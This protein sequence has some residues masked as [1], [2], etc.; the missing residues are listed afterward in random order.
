MIAFQMGGVRVHEDGSAVAGGDDVMLDDRAPHGTGTQAIRRRLLAARYQADAAARD[1]SGVDKQGAA[2]GAR[3]MS[4][5]REL[6]A[7]VQRLAPAVQALGAGEKEALRPVTSALLGAAWTLARKEARQ[8][9]VYDALLADVT[10]LFGV[11]QRALRQDG[12]S[13]RDESTGETVVDEDH[14]AVGDARRRIFA[15]RADGEVVEAVHIEVAPG[16]GSAEGVAGLVEVKPEGTLEKLDRGKRRR[17]VEPEGG[18]GA[19]NDG[20]RAAPDRAGD[21][22]PRRAD[23]DIRGAVAVEVLARGVSAERPEEGRGHESATNDGTC[24]V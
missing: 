18:P 5:L 23:G 4:V 11:A 14:A 10:G 2:G 24:H 22:L 19:E 9:V 17:A 6:R 13:D 20:D 12:R 1:L 3:V 16:N 7:E 21:G 8:K 15:R